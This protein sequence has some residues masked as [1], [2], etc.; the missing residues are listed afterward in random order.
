MKTHPS[1]KSRIATASSAAKS[2]RE[3]LLDA[4]AHLFAEQGIAET[5]LANIAGRIGVT[6]AMIHYYFKTRDQ[7]LDAFVTE[8]IAPLIFQVWNPVID[9]G[10]TPIA[11]IQGLIQRI[12]IVGNTPWLPRIWIREIANEGGLL[13]EKIIKCVPYEGIDHFRRNIETAQK[14][15]IM[16]PHIDP[17]LLA[18]SII[19]MTMLP[20]A[21]AKIWKKIPEFKH[22]DQ[23]RLSRHI[24]ALLM[25]GVVNPTGLSPESALKK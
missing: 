25:H 14:E 5:T 13:R 20:L 16:N 8:R 21:T 18:L 4:A 3:R 23:Q 7:L 11:V 15:G 12:L 2:T 17:G 22:V 9:E 24:T 6:S 10:G 1:S 19:S